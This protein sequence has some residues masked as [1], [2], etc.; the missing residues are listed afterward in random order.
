MQLYSILIHMPN[1]EQTAPKPWYHPTIVT[2]TGKKLLNRNEPKK[3]KELTELELLTLISGSRKFA[4]E[5][6]ENKKSILELTELDKPRELL[7]FPSATDGVVAR[8]WAAL[9]L[10]ARVKESQILSS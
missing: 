2:K 4:R 1:L 10:L 9:E 7:V 5:F 6:L 3:S 8:V